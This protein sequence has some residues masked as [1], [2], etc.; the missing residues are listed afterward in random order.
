[1]LKNMG[2]VDRMIRII[3]A[4]ILALFIFTGLV[5]SVG[6][7]VVAVISFYLLL[8]GIFRFC[9]LYTI[10]GIHTLR[11]KSGVDD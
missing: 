9:L 7:I 5:K 10:V 1:M 8:T 11:T 2:T 4:I 3:I 6:L